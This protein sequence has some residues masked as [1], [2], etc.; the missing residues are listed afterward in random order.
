MRDLIQRLEIIRYVLT[1]PQSGSG[2][3]MRP[4]LV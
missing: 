4:V 1:K 2:S 3:G